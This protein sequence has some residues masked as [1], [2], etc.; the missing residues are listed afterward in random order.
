MTLEWVHVV[1][2]LFLPNLFISED[3]LCLIARDRFRSQRAP[4]I[5]FH[6]N[7]EPAHVAFY[8][9][10]NTAPNQFVSGECDPEIVCFQNAVWKKDK[11]AYDF[12]RHGPQEINFIHKESVKN[13]AERADV[14]M[15]EMLTD[16]TFTPVLAETIKSVD[17]VRIEWEANMLRTND[18]VREMTELKLEKV[19]E[20]YLTHPKIKQGHATRYDYICWAYRLTWPNYN[21]VYLWHEAL[22]LLLPGDD[23]EHKHASEKINGGS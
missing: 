7:V 20:V 21:T 11:E 3:I 15:K 14:L 16:S 13:L 18:M 8:L 10:S 19:V 17:Q 2:D 1:R 6:F 22:H 12:I 5:S 4:M 23:V 9:I